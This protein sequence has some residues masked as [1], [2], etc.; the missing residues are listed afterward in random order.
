M[1][2]TLLDAVGLYRVYAREIPSGV[3][4]VVVSP[5]SASGGGITFVPGETVDGILE[6]WG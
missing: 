1:S 5:E 6:A 4:V 3:F 2:W